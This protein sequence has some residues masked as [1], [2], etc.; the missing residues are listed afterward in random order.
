MNVP[1]GRST[2]Q[3]SASA[4]FRSQIFMPSDIE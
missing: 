3:A 2:R 1:P 4:N